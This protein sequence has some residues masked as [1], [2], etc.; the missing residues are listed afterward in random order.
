MTKEVLNHLRDLEENLKDW[1]AYL[2]DVSEDRFIKDRLSRHALLHCVLV[3][4]QSAID[5]GNHWLTELT[6][7]RPES[8][9]AIVDLLEGEKVLPKKLARD[10]KGLFSLRNVLIHKYAELNLKKIYS[11]LKKG[12]KPL[13]E[14]LK[15]A[16]SKASRR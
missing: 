1:E 12:I 7:E 16:K 10:L 13:R 8:Y 14:Y 9:R 6:V 2:A 11:Y 5:I 4:L 15:T 3:A